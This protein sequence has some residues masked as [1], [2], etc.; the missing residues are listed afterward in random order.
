MLWLRESSISAWI[1]FTRPKN[2]GLGLRH[3]GET[4]EAQDTKSTFEYIT[5]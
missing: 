5:E 3:D 1:K 2:E 4:D